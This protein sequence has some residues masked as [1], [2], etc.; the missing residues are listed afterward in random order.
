M[1][2]IYI[3]NEHNYII[4]FVH[5][6]VDTFCFIFTNCTS[7]SLRDAQRTEACSQRGWGVAVG[8]WSLSLGIYISISL[9]LSLP[10]YI[11]IYIYV[12][13]YIYRERERD[14]YIYIYRVFRRLLWR[15]AGGR[16]ERRA[17]CREMG[18][19]RSSGVHAYMM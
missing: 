2:Y 8:F 5:V 16:A 1:I 11:Y 14:I 12:Y 9:S 19:K 17:P 4:I 6:L 3:C 15:L 18:S 10:V 13:I 7:R